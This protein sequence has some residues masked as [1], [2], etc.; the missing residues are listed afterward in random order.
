MS[1]HGDGRSSTERGYGHAWRKLRTTILKR[2]GH[3]CQPCKRKGRLTA[4]TQVDHIVP[5]AKH[6]TDHPSNLQAICDECHEAK[7]ALDNG[8]RPAVRIGI[9]GFPVSEPA[10]RAGSG[11]PL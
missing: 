9:D 8:A 5:K 2:D 6:G 1:W 3:Q 7:T 4:A 11:G 10:G